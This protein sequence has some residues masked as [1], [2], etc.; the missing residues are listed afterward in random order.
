MFERGDAA[1]NQPLRCLAPGSPSV[2]TRDGRAFSIFHLNY[3][4]LGLFFFFF[5]LVH[6]APRVY[7]GKNNSPCIFQRREY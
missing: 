3:T 7:R 1:I 6:C 2:T 5:F 4:L